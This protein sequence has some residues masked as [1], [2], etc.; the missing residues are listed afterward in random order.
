MMQTA[1]NPGATE[2]CNGIDDDCDGLT[3]DADPSITG[4]GTYFT[5][6]DGDNFGTGAPILA[7]VQPI[8]TALVDGDC[9]DANAA[10]NPAAAELCNG[11]DD[12]CNGLTDDGVAPLPTPGTIVGT[13]AACLPATFGS[14]TFT[15]APVAGATGYTW[16]VPAGFTI[17]AGQGSTTITVQW[18]NVSIHNGI[19]GN[20]CVTAVGTCSSSLPSCVFVEYHI[21]APVMPNSISGPGKVCPGDVATYSI[22][23]VA[24]ATSYN[25][26]LPAGMTITSGAGTNVINVLVN[27]AYTGGTLSVSA[28]NVCGTGAART[29]AM[30]LNMPLTPGVIAGQRFGLC[31]ST[32]VVFSI[33]AV[34]NATSYLWTIS[35]GTIVSGQ[36]T[37]TISVDVATLTGTGTLSVVA[38]NNCGSSS[39]RSTTFFGIPDRA[40]PITGTGTPC[41]NTIE[42]YSVATVAGASL[43]TWSVST[44]G[45]IVT[46]QGSKNITVQW[47]AAPISGQSL[48]IF[49][50]NACGV[51]ATRSLTAINVVACPRIGV[52]ADVMAMTVYPNPARENVTVQ[53]NSDVQSQYNLR[54]LDVT[55]RVVFNEAGE[56]VAGMNMKEIKLSEIQSGVYFIHMESAG[57]SEITR[58]V[59]E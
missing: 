51:S 27:G 6:A 57:Q 4:Q 54:L 47:S 37:T 10:I 52:G 11:I 20:M 41:A 25:W 16:S 14:T 56:S 28:T 12:N 50:S 8:G 9:N 40:Q 17:L 34:A 26:T 39:V 53:F 55:G 5:D 45:A 59:I 49:T 33:P 13:A 31:N 21:A 18:T 23:A 32:G 2:I 15:V 38:V 3:D 48:S 30:S 1:V 24:R 7:C 22:A 44:G 29:K 58:L 46:G 36:G 42:P 35:G 19:S 43:Y